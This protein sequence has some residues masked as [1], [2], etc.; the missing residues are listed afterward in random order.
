[1]K[2]TARTA[3][4]TA[5]AVTAPGRS[6]SASGSSPARTSALRASERFAIRSWKVSSA[7]ASSPWTAA[8]G[9]SPVAVA[10]GS[11]SA[12]LARRAALSLVPLG[13]PALAAAHQPRSSSHGRLDAGR[14]RAAAAARVVGVADRPHDADPPRAG[15]DD[16]ARRSPRRSRRS[17][18]REARTTRRPSPIRSSPVAGLPCLGRRLPDRADA[19]VVD[20]LALGGLDLLGRVGGE[21]DD[22]VGPEDLPRLGRRHVVLADVDAV[23]VE[24][25]GEV[26]IVVDDEERAEGVGQPP[27]GRGRAPDR[28]VRLLAVAQLDHP[29]AVRERGAEQRLGVLAV[30]QRVADEVEARPAEPLAA[31]VPD[32]L[33]RAEAA[34]LGRGG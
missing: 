1:M 2:I 11:G 14:E 9:S 31:K 34:R 28:A 4:T 17:R 24:L 10:V 33:G 3:E 18:T 32:S 12:G 5:P 8:K 23:R 22:R 26:G 25:A 19:D 7:V 20:G 15:V 29:G 16:L 27:E 21:P 30:G 13:A 6:P